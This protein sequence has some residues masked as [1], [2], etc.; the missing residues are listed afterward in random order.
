L[1]PAGHVF[2]RLELGVV[3]RPALG[4]HHLAVVAV[5][6]LPNKLGR[7]DLGHVHGRGAPNTQSTLIKQTS[8]ALCTV[9]ASRP[10][11]RHL[12]SRVPVQI[13][14]FVSLADPVS[15]Q[16]LERSRGCIGAFG[17]VDIDIVGDRLDVDRCDGKNNAGAYIFNNWG[18]RQPR[19]PTASQFERP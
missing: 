14:P 12:G 7:L 13:C 9:V 17:V 10:K 19:G 18:G 1:S 4:V 11:A 5:A 2:A 15:K 6:Q 8:S 16:M 3:S